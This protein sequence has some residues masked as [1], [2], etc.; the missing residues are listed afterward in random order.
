MSEAML[1][2]SLSA[3]SLV[4]QAAAEVLAQQLRVAG[5]GHDRPGMGLAASDHVTLPFFSRVAPPRTKGKKHIQFDTQ[6]KQ[7]IASKMKGIADEE[8]ASYTILDDDN[9]DLDEAAV[10]TRRT[11]SKPGPPVVLSTQSAEN[12]HVDRKIIEMVPSGTVKYREDSLPWEIMGK[13]N[14]AKVCASGSPPSMSYEEDEA[15]KGLLGEM[16][17]AA[18]TATDI[19]YM[20]WNIGWT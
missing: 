16:I 3:S 10:I 13:H 2:R 7:R 18:N 8:L 5:P 20:I 6:V 12:I 15:P 4:K 9:S 11:R 19:A 17:D 1:Q 14:S